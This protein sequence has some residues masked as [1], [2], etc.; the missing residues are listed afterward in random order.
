MDGRHRGILFIKLTFPFLVPSGGAK[1]TKDATD[2]L[3]TSRPGDSR[4]Y[5]HKSRDRHKEIANKMGTISC[6][7][8]GYAASRLCLVFITPLNCYL[9][10]E[11]WHRPENPAWSCPCNIYFP[12]ELAAVLGARM[13]IVRIFQLARNNGDPALCQCWDGIGD[14]GPTLTQSWIAC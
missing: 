11:Q 13:F 2:H 12:R 1:Q 8:R 9:A 7:S 4:L 10:N 3:F 5:T 14:A 6:L